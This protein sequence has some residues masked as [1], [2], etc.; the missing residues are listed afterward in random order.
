MEFAF[1]LAELGRTRAERVERFRELLKICQSTDAPVLLPSDTA[2]SE[3]LFRWQSP[4]ARLECLTDPFAR[5][6]AVQD[7]EFLQP[8]GA[9]FSI[10]T[11][12]VELMDAATEALVDA[13]LKQTKVSLACSPR[14]CGAPGGIRGYR[15]GRRAGLPLSD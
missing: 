1:D 15:D 5:A 12:L 11:V 9:L 13:F 3:Y 2:E 7:D 6:A 10:T 8:I 4:T 14:E